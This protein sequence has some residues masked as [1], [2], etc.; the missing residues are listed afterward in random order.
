VSKGI[1]GVNIH[2]ARAVGNTFTIDKY[3]AGCQ[4]FQNADDFETFMKLCQKHRAL[5]GNSFTYT[6]ID[7][8]AVRRVTLKRVAMAASLIVSAVIGFIWKG[9]FHEDS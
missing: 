4:V 5:Y 8:R 7:F 6:L 9:G 1:F 3:S 2:H